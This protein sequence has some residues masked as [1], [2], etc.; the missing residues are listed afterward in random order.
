MEGGKAGGGVLL[1]VGVASK[2]GMEIMIFQGSWRQRRISLELLWCVAVRAFL[3]RSD[4]KQGVF[5]MSSCTRLARR[6]VRT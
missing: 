5:V 4:Q 1:G 2:C 3:R 6:Q